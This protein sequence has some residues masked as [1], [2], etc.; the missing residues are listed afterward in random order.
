MKSKS[1]SEANQYMMIEY[2][3]PVS[4]NPVEVLQGII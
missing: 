4:T 3:T 1:G 2:L